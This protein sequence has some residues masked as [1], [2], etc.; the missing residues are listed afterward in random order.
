[1]S[2]NLCRCGKPTRDAAYVCDPCGQELATA[3]GDVA[4]LDEQ[5]EITITR[6]S[7]VDYRTLGGTASSETPSPVHWVA[8]DARGHLKALLVSWAL[9]A[10]Q[11]DVRNSAP[12]S[13]DNQTRPQGA[14]TPNGLSPA[15][16]SQP[17]RG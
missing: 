10:Y 14:E 3:L 9:F 16:L 4:W 12:C 5:L 8:S 2:E 13:C 1:M 11:E 7:G 15:H 17:E 6:T